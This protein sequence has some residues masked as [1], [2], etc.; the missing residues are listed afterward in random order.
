M[1]PNTDKHMLIFENLENMGD[2]VVAQW[3][4]ESN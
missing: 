4:K 3:V 1:L 2:A